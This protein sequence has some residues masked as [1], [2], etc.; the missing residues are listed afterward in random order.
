MKPAASDLAKTYPPRGPLQLFRFVAATAFRCFRC[1]ETKKSKL[2]GV[3]ADNW[4]RRLCNGC[5]GRLLSIYEIKAGGGDVQ[6]RADALAEMLLNAVSIDD[7]RRARLLLNV[8]DRRAE[9]LTPSSL[10]F[11]AS[12]EFVA[13][14]FA[15]TPAL[16]WSPAV[17]GLC[18]AA[19][20]ELVAHLLQPLAKASGSRNL[21]ADRADNDI[22]RVAAFCAEPTRK[23]PELGTIAHFLQTVAHSESRRA[24]SALVR[25]FLGVISEWTDATWVLSPTGLQRSLA[26]LSSEFRNPAA[27][28][29]EL[30]EGDYRACRDLVIGGEG[31]LWRLHLASQPHR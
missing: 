2:I 14:Q 25:A 5:Y 18:K 12:S 7:V 10:R 27:H 6:F 28:T 13:T 17:I 19:E 31:I 3:Y 9:L 8:A 24:T 29:D 16:E 22:G 20:M 11:V 1:G 26:R 30:S 21:S 23:P 4:E 15:D